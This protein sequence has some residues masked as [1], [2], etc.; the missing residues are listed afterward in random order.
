MSD[1]ILTVQQDEAANRFTA[2]VDGC[3][4]VVDY[5]FR[6]NTLAIVHTGVPQ[7]VGGRGIAGELTRQ[8]LDIARARG[9]R[10][11]PQCSYTAAYIARH[12]SY[13]DLVA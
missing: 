12:P 10:V 9:W 4:C 11:I 1:T 7:E 6:D 13:Q 3:T 2:N 5:Q 8:V